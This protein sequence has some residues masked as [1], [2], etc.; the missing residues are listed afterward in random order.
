MNENKTTYGKIIKKL[1]TERDLSQ[2]EL[3]R[4]LGRSRIILSQIETGVRK[5]HA[6]EIRKL[7]KI[8][9]VSADIVLGIKKQPRAKLEKAA[10]RKK[11]TTPIRITVPQKNV[12][13]FKEVLLYILNKV[14][15][16]PN[17]GET[18]IYKLLYFIDFDYYEKYEEQLIGAS[19]IKNRYG[20]TPIEFGKIVEALIN[21]GEIEPIK[22]KYFQ[23]PQRKYLPIRQPTLSLL[24]A[25][26][27]KVIDDVLDRLSDMNAIQ[28]SNYSHNDVPWLT[29]DEEGIIEYES[30][31]YRTPPYSVREYSEEEV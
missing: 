9:G 22:S 7:S 15:S 8:L 12:E 5:I 14:G 4:R 13:K 29:A 24:T 6:D 21:S 23:H 10:K 16:K 1:R 25:E 31:F 26:E 19:Y 2:E 20:P 17:V 11:K 18:V 27:L 3:S 30:V 28:I